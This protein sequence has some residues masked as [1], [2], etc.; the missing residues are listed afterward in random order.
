MSADI[1][2]RAPGPWL[3][4]DSAS[5]LVAVDTSRPAVATTS[6]LIRR[7]WA[8]RVLEMDCHPQSLAA[9]VGYIALQFVLG[10]AVS[11]LG[12]YLL[13]SIPWL[14]V[15]LYPFLVFFLGTRFRAL[16][17]MIHEA[18]HGTLVR[19]K[20]RNRVLG[21]LLAIVDFVCFDTYTREHFSHHSFLGDARKDLDFQQRWRFGFGEGTNGRMGTRHLWFPLLLLHLPVYVRPVLFSRRDPW[22][23]SVGRLLFVAGLLALCH[24]VG[25]KA[26]S[27]F[28]AVPFFVAYQV[29]R[30]WSDALDHAG[31]LGAED[32]FFR[33]RNHVLGAWLLNRLLFPRND[34]YHLTHHLFPSVPTRAQA[35]VH[36]LLMGEPVYAAREHSFRNAI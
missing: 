2:Q 32:E 9:V 22:P 15:C 35:R 23:V 10:A 34:E 8:R 18:S 21:H 30:Y 31:C 28:Y 3:A 24:Q 33:T 25:W 16:G 7:A 29:I 17:N 14:G 20:R 13:R 4:P 36:E 26:F 12:V 6:T 1:P 19:G 27:L 5:L 11:A